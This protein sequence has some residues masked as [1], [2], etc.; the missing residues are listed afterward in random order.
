MNALGTRCLGHMESD[1]WRDATLA[2]LFFFI[3][4]R[5]VAGGDC[6]RCDSV[7]VWIAA[8]AVIVV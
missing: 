6:L 7:R 8:V 4:P 1:D 3:L 5:R 2:Y